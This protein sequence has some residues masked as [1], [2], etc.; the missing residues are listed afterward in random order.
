MN[1]FEL[2]LGTDGNMR[3]YLS[4]DHVGTYSNLQSAVIHLGK[5][6]LDNRKMAAEVQRLTA[7]VDRL[8]KDADGDPL[9]PNTSYWFT[10]HGSLMRG[11]Y[12]ISAIDVNEPRGHASDFAPNVPGAYHKTREAAEAKGEARA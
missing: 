8:P 5:A 2:T 11:I 12:T 4:G 10:S 6:L 3:L 7:I 1:E 9:Q